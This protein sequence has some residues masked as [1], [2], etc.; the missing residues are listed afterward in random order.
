MQ[1]VLFSIYKITNNI[2][3]KIYIGKSKNPYKRFSTHKTLAIKY[4]GLYECTKLYRSIRK[5]G[6]ENFSLEILESFQDEKS[7][8]ESERS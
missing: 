8:Y 7:S 2:N 3:N 5:Y 4:K 6:K 1:E